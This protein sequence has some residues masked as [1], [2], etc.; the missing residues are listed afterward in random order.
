MSKR[1]FPLPVKITK[2][3]YRNQIKSRIHGTSSNAMR[4]LDL[5]GMDV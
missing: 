5:D 1:Y 4:V 3:Q 2:Y